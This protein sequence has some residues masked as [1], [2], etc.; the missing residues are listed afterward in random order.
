MVS[1]QQKFNWNELAGLSVE[2]IEKK[3]R[4]ILARM[5]LDQKVHQMSGDGPFVRGSIDMLKRYNKEPYVAGE[6]KD[7]GIKGIHFADGPRGV[8]MGKSTCFPVSM[9]RGASFDPELEERIGDVIGIEGR[10]QGANFFG[11]VCI[12]LLRH[13]AWGRAQETYGEDPF[14]LGIMGSALVRGTQKHVMACAKHFAANSME[15]ARFKVDINIDERTLREVYLP[16]FRK[17]V[18]AGVASLMSAYNK[19]NGEHC[20]HNSHLLRD[21]LKKDWNFKG[22]VISDF[23]LGVR[24]A[25][26]GVNGGLDIE[27]PFGWK[28]KPGKLVK[29]VKKGEI[30]E[31]H[32]DEAV[33]RI[34]R[35]K[36]LFNLDRDPD[37]YNQAKV[38][39]KEHVQ[40]ALEAAR[41]STVLLK[42]DNQLLPLDR[43]DLKKIAV[44][45]K[46][47]DKENTG[48]MGSSKV[49][50]PHVITPFQGIKNAAGE[51]VEVI[52]D[53]GRKIDRA[54]KLARD[55][56]V[57]IIVAGY[58]HE[59]E[60][61]YIPT[62]GFTKGGD[63]DSLALTPHDE[64]L[65]SAL[66]DD[67]PDCTVI[68]EGGS[69]IMTETWNEKVPAILMAWYPGMEG[70]TALGE[71]IFGDTNPSGKLPVVFPENQD[72]LPF[73]DKDTKKIDYGYYHGY[74]LMDKQDNRA[75]FA[76]GYGL[77]YTTYSYANPSVDKEEIVNN[78]AVTISIDVTNTGNRAGEEIVQLYIGYR[79]SAVDRPVKDLKGFQRV[80]LNPGETKTVN[81]LLS[82]TDLA[83]YDVTTKGW[84]IEPIDYIVHVGSSSRKEDL[85]TTTFK[86]R[87]S[88]PG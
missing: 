39:C 71:I 15:N 62:P 14:L 13:P 6:D 29:L 57:V 28:M 30:S 1:N 12:N 72:Q 7:L 41:K 59:E 40:L 84:K 61:E 83:Y 46:L 70:G 36:L 75:A 51:N 45:G 18:E 54:K 77:S 16:H 55:A 82:A 44:I 58:T 38:A 10:S 48:D 50:P 73:F 8:V 47:A 23:T 5:T 21:I 65:I 33:I 19:V 52:S 79:N 81:M 76:F 25:R 60:G 69:A 68:L 66:S 49:Y 11:G 4:E 63:R 64:K 27:M 22:F 3:A 74:R 2:E 24:D 86:V 53:D 26:A 43:Q 67:N 20:G 32:I 34:L 35:Q 80:A 85:L 88:T 42:N 31:K 9:A 78:G 37:L 56:D 17:C 87:S